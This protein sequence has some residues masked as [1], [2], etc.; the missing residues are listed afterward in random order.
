MHTNLNVGDVVYVNNSLAGSGDFVEEN[1]AYLLGSVARVIGLDP[2]DRR[3][4]RVGDW[5]VE[6]QYV[7]PVPREKLNSENVMYLITAGME[8]SGQV[9]IL[10]YYSVH[11]GEVSVESLGVNKGGVHFSALAAALGI[12][13]DTLEVECSMTV[14]C[15][16]VI[17][18]A[19]QTLRGHRQQVCLGRVRLV[20]ILDGEPYLVSNSCFVSE[21]Y[22]E[23]L[24][25]S[26][27]D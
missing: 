3:D 1:M 9:T 16:V 26:I 27:G 13:V 11:P 17:V 21:D 19:W 18:H 4:V 22:M 24:T 12:S 10:G 15:G 25:E 14:W 23:D 8:D 20:G 6:S 2:V 7:T 5:W